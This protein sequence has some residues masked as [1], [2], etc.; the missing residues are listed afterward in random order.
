MND[1][2]LLVGRFF[3]TLPT[4][5]NTQ[6]SELQLDASGRLIIAGRYAV[7]TAS[8]ASDP[9]ILMLGQRRDANTTI[10]TADG[11][12]APFQLDATGRVKV[13]AVVSVEPSDAEFAEDSPNTSGDTGLHMLSVRQDTLATSTSADGDYADIKVNALG[14]LYTH[15]TSAISQLTTANSTLTTIATNTGNTATN[16]STISA[17]L[18]ALSKAEDSPA[19]DGSQGIQVFAQRHD[20]NTGT[21]SADGDLSLLHVNAQGRL[22]TETTLSQIGSEQ[23]T[24]TDA[25][26]AAG[27]GLATITAAATPWVDVATLA[28]PSGTTA[29]VYGWQWGCDANADARIVTD[30]TTD[31][32]VYK[33]S[34]NSSAT[35]SY[36]EHWSEGGRIEIPGATDLEVKVQIKKRSAA[37]GN[38]LGTGSIHIRTV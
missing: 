16:T 11:N 30:D 22:K 32:I 12:Y 9:A 14:E 10:A 37:G 5:T 23:Y 33:R 27:D 31:V 29:Y 3:T 25:L 36:T 8:A 24:V 26:A 7:D 6:L 19:V 15:D 35:P 18:T 28:V 21:V 2:G 17:T 1:F 34:V 38:A 20:A 4:L 13:A